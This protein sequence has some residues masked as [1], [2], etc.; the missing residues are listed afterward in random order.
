MPKTRKYVFYCIKNQDFYTT[1][2]RNNNK[3]LTQIHM[4]SNLSN[5]VYNVFKIHNICSS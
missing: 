1:N 3:I 5:T 4:E 2:N